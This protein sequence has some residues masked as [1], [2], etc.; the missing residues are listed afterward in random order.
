V[1]VLF[2]RLTSDTATAATMLGMES[3]IRI[4]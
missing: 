3:Q 4:Q 1:Q 2:T